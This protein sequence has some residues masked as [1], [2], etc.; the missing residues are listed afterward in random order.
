MDHAS[1]CAVVAT[2]GEPRRAPPNRGGR[3]SF[4]HL[5]RKALT[6]LRNRGQLALDMG[7]ELSNRAP[8]TK[9]PGYM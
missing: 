7:E 9:L 4:D 8:E 3:S 1:A 6:V 5:S 2:L